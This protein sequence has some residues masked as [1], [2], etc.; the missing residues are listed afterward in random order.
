MSTRELLSKNTRIQQGTL[1]YNTGKFHFRKVQLFIKW[2][3]PTLI[4][5]SKRFCH[6]RSNGSYNVIITNLAGWILSAQRTPVMVIS[7]WH[8]V[9]NYTTTTTLLPYKN[10]HH[11][12]NTTR[13]WTTVLKP[14]SVLFL[15]IAPTLQIPRM[16]LRLLAWRNIKLKKKK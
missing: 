7:S 4:N 9:Q 8:D 14:V 11:S 16:W 13:H 12:Q 2:V 3:R 6:L 1:L 10:S 15:L 5:S